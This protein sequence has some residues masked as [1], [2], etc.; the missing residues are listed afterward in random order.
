MAQWGTLL[1]I[2]A[3]LQW[4]ITG[5]LGSQLMSWGWQAEVISFWRAMVGFIC[6]LVWMFLLGYHKRPADSTRGLL[7]WSLLAG[8]G[9]AGNF[10]FYFK[11]VNESSVAVAATLMYSAPI[12]VYIAS[13]LARVEKPTPTKLASI[14]VVMIGIVLLTGVLQSGSASVTPLGIAFGLSA[15]VSYA[16][17]IF[18]FKSASRHGSVPGILAIALGLST[19]IMVPFTDMGQAI[20]VPFADEWWVFILFGLV[21]GG[22][23]FYCYIAGLRHSLPSVAS[24]VAMIEPITATLYGLLILGQGLSAMQIG[25]MALILLAITVLSLAQN[26]PDVLLR[27]PLGLRKDTSRD[28][29]AKQAEQTSQ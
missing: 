10:M 26:R 5:G 22:L 11:S 20:A 13:F 17:F 8:L 1:V 21:G 18:A 29:Q 12:F 28:A 6:M 23:S 24:I 25:G 15:G 9:V 7:G 16:V 3:A 4:G 14:V 2:L 27:M 19:L